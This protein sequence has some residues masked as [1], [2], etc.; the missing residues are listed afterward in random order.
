MDYGHAIE[1]GAFLTPTAAEPATV[2]ALAR[3][4]EAAGLDLVTFQDHPY[5][6]AFLDTWTLM[7]WVAAHTDRVRIAPN[8]LNVPLRPPAVVARAAASLDRLSGGRL[9][10]GLG[11][12]GFWDAIDAMGGRRLTPGQ[13]V[14]ALEEA[15]DVIRGLWNTD[16][17]GGIFTDGAYYRV[18]GA[19]RGPRPTH[20]IPI[21]LGA[22]RPR[23]LSL[24]GRKGDGWLPSLGHLQP[25]DL[26]R[27]NAAI[28][29]AAAAVGRSPTDIRRL[30]N[31]G[32]LAADER[33]WAERLSSLALDDG[34][35]TFILA[36]D[37][38]NLLAL[39][40]REIAPAVR[41][42][43]RESRGT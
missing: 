28:D 10:L 39:F 37:D 7:T 33:E 43:V 8:V 31:V 41:E 9:D 16:E 32:R 4:A 29:E 13:S 3:E 24:T 15:I 6:P 17:K 14:T 2:V 18:R 42:I 21:I 20:D 5:Q 40:G 30:L 19:K 25:G 12:G 38:P 34:V 11:A 1:F 23:M 35:S 27:G 22:Y 26:A 36:T